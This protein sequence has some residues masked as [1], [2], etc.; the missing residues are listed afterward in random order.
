ML[1]ETIREENLLLPRGCGYVCV[2][3]V[4]VQ[5]KSQLPENRLL[6]ISGPEK[7]K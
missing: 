7:D 4:T 5:Q 1:L 3:P 2:K 6:K